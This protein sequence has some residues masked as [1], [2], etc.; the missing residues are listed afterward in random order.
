MEK[1]E[2]RISKVRGKNVYLLGEDEE[3]TKYWLEEAN[4]D[5]AWYWGFGYV[6]TYT[7]NNNPSLARDINSHQHFDSMFLKKG[8]FSSYKSFFAKSTLKEEEIW[9]L[10]ELMQTF[11]TL[12]ETAILLHCGGSY[13]T[14]NPLE[15]LLKSEEQEKEINEKILPALFTEVYKLLTPEN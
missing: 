3:G 14:S 2:K 9:Q 5:C 10:L 4:W 11:Y 7:N 13:V 12:K 6:E 15:N 8:T 1:L